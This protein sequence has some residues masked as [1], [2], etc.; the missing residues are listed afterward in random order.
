MGDLVYPPVIATA[1]AAFR[2]WDMRFEITG[3]ERIPSGGPVILA[4]NHVS[5]LDFLFLGLAARPS[6]RYVRFLTMAEA[7]RHPVGGPLLRG[8]HHIPVDRSRA[9]SRAGAYRF[10][11]RALRGGEVVGIFPEGRIGPGTGELLPFRPG[12]ARLAAATGVAVLP[13]A[14][15]GGQELWTAGHRRLTRRH[16]P[17]GIRVGRPVHVPPDGDPEPWSETIRDRVARLAGEAADRTR[18]S[19]HRP[20][21]PPPARSK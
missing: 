5:F 15:W 17:I 2:L 13:M 20:P 10:A 4:A 3:A 7:F 11:E 8:M 19:P 12:A 21:D 16:A 1:L 9:E 18:R 14:V 6:R